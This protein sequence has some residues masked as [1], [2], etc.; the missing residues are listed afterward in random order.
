MIPAVVK[1]AGQ[2]ARTKTGAVIATTTVAR[3]ARCTQ[4]YVQAVAKILKFRSSPVV[5]S[6]CIAE[7]ALGSVPLTRILNFK[8][9]IG[10]QNIL[11]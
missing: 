9:G 4:L 3:N 5:K 6:L 8:K 10:I 7:I 1:S 2:P 11:I